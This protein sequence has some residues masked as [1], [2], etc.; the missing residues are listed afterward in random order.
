VGAPSYRLRLAYGFVCGAAAVVGCGKIAGI[1]GLTIGACDKGIC[2]DAA[3]DATSRQ[4]SGLMRRDASSRDMGT[5]ILDAAR[6]AP[7]Q[8]TA[9]GHEASV[10]D[11]RVHDAAPSNEC[12]ALEP[13]AMVAVGAASNRFCIDSTEV[14]F[15]QYRSFVAAKGNDHSGQPAECTWNQSFLASLPGTDGQPVVG[16]DWCDAVAYCEWAGK[17]LCGGQASGVNT[18]G[19]LDAAILDPA[20]SQWFIACSQEGVLA[21]PYGQS[22]VAGRCN[23][24]IDAGEGYPADGST[25][26]GGYPGVVNLIGNVWEFFDSC[27]RIDGG[28]YQND[29]CVIFGGGFDSLATY[30]CR[31]YAGPVLRGS[32]S[33]AN[34]GFR[35][36]SK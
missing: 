28:S 22:Y 32:P 17:R 13:P 6:D 27:E 2:A 7:Q 11:A 19:V 5:A 8:T 33:G 10:S 24:G 23:I 3:A 12:G 36:C 25:C 16:I 21:Y 15:G 14:T 20:V 9:G 26:I 18:G 34:L 1:D 31:V 29:P 35:C 4:D 30:N